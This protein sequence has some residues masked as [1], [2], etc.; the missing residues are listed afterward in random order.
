[1]K[2]GERV[3]VWDTTDFLCLGW[4]TIILIATRQKD[5]EDLPFIHLD[6]GEKVWGDKVAWIT[7]EKAMKIG[8]T[9][10]LDILKEQSCD[11]I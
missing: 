2:K 3:Q 10:F 4:G 9:I 5:K 8:R 6:S 7:E 1:M 11:P